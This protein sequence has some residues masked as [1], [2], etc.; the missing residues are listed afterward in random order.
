MIK[1]RQSIGM[2]QNQQNLKQAVQRNPKHR[3]LVEKARQERKDK[4]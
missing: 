1:A 3:Q 2:S 4:Q